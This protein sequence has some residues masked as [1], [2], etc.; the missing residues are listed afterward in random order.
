[1]RYATLEIVLTSPGCA[2]YR[3]LDAAGRM[4]WQNRVTNAPA[5]HQAARER[6]AAWAVQHGYK[7]VARKEVR[8]K[9]G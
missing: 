5:G 6:L 7:V 3:L 4:V 1:M 9:A 2:R 8:Q